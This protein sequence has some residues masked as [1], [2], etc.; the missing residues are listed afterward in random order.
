MWTRDREKT[1]FIGIWTKSK[2]F[3][4]FNKAII[5]LIKYI[6]KKKKDEKENIG[7]S[8]E[9]DGFSLVE[10]MKETDTFDSKQN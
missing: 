1:W 7:E 8:E 3:L 10:A 6:I 2:L 4:Y 9:D 5:I